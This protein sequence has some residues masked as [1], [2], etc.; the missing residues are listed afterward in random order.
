MSLSDNLNLKGHPLRNPFWR[1]L[2]EEGNITFRDNYQLELKSEFFIDP[3]ASATHFSQ[4]FYL[5][6]PETLQINPHSYSAEQ[7]YH[8]QLNLIRFKTPSLSL[9][10][11]VDA[12]NKNSPLYRIQNSEDNDVCLKEMMLYGNIFRTSLRYRIRNILKALQNRKAEGSF[13]RIESESRLLIQDVTAA[14]QA[15]LKTKQVL[16]D[17]FALKR[18]TDQLNYIDEF[19]TIVS[20]E[21]FSLLL[22]ILREQKDPELI[23]VDTLLCDFLDEEERH[24][25]EL[26]PEI[27]P[28]NTKESTL[29]RQ[30]LLEKFMLDALKLKNT[31]IEVKQQYGNIIGATA[32]GFAMFVY[33]VLFVWKASTFVINSAPFVFF[34]VFFYILKDRIKEGMKMLY[35]RYINRW[36]PDF[37]T[38]IYDSKG[39]VIGLLSE[40]FLFIPRKKLPEGFYDLRMRNVEDKLEFH[41]PNESIIQYKKDVKLYRS[42]GRLTELTTIF[43]YNILHFL[44]KANDSVQPIL[45]LDPETHI[46]EEQLLAKVY[47][48]NFILKSNFL[49]ANKRRCEEIKVFMIVIDKKGIKRVE[50]ISSQLNVLDNGL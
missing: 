13:N 16:I 21:Y 4:E 1:E 33:M 48:L 47:H 34:A 42:Q 30:G 7:F 32:A 18:F 17:R 43:R 29:Y 14:K 9:T 25:L 15:F 27:Y 24:R 3:N 36:F 10:E 23:S 38:H 35:N 12:K 22:R 44:E 31:R 5:F 28:D 8:D 45:K 37:R 2:G 40:S 6:V 26:N 20:E 41:H 19:M 46:L 39:K 50:Q 49:D 11:L